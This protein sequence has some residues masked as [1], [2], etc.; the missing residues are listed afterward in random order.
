MKERELKQL[1]LDLVDLM[2][3]R[4]AGPFDALTALH[5]AV[6]HVLAT[7]R[8]EMTEAD[9]DEGLK[10]LGDV[11]RD[12]WRFVRQLVRKHFRGQG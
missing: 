12:E 4:G 11:T 3:K 6:A 5:L 7:S 8:P 10:L 2:A 9:L 1:V